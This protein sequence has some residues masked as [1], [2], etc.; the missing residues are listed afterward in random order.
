MRKIFIVTVFV[1]S[2]LLVALA[3][4][5]RSVKQNTPSE[6]LKDLKTLGEKLSSSEDK[7]TNEEI[8]VIEK[9]MD[10]LLAKAIKEARKDFP[11]VKKALGNKEFLKELEEH[12]Y[13]KEAR[14]MSHTL[15]SMERIFGIYKPKP[16]SP[17]E[18][19]AQK[20]TNEGIR[21]LHRAWL[22]DE[23]VLE[24]KAIQKFKEALK[25]APAYIPPY[26]KLGIIYVYQEKLNE[27]KEMVRKAEKIGSHVRQDYKEY[28]IIKN[29]M[30]NIQKTPLP[31]E[32]TKAYKT[33]RIKENKKL[34]VWEDELGEKGYEKLRK[35]LEQARE[36]EEKKKFHS[37][38][39]T[40]DEILAMY[41][42]CEDAY[43]KLAKIYKTLLQDDKAI[44]MYKKAFD[45]NPNS[46]W[47]HWGMANYYE[48]K[49]MYDQAKAEYQKVIAL[50]PE[51]YMG[52][53]SRWELA[54]IKRKE[55]RPK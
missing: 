11:D 33:R 19:K 6:I 5:N 47:G 3:L 17:Q 23:R 40:Y 37:A 34:D 53:E 12:G 45:I 39:K 10:E 29:F 8:A 25:I 9:R 27:A 2:A 50:D 24:Q 51:G 20:I 55:N 35:A 38:I 1:S 44:Q 46:I 4:F 43:I 26:M 21:L 48:E 16:L 32:Y 28:F 30:E 22:R 42:H 14:Q 15:E 52:D 7:L 49:G 18:K 41:P 31:L 36:E 54:D 13:T